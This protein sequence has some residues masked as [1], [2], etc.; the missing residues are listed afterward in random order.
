MMLTITG[1]RQTGKSYALMLL[2]IDAAEDGKRVFYQCTDR[3][4]AHQ[5]FLDLEQK[6]QCRG[7][8]EKSWRTN[9]EQRL[10]LTSGGEIYLYNRPIN[11]DVLLADDLSSDQLSAVT[12]ATLA[13]RVAWARLE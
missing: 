3:R 4:L 11:A 12:L 8:L 5:R 7:I 1:D 10:R 13:D 9:G 2:A 6:C